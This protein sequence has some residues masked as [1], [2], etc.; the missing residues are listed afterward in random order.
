MSPKKH[1]D[2]DHYL[3]SKKIEEVQNM[4]WKEVRKS[5]Q[6]KNISIHLDLSYQFFLLQN[7]WYSVKTKFD[8]DLG[9]LIIKKN[10]QLNLLRVYG[11]KD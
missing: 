10:I 9:F 11:L 6:Q 4:T 8:E 3:I 2:A 5:N 7:K 1:V